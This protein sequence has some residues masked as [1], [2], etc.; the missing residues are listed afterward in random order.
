MSERSS[1]SFASE[2]SMLFSLICSKSL[3]KTMIAK[4]NT[5][6]FL[7]AA[8]CASWSCAALAEPISYTFTAE[9]PIMGALGGA[10]IGGMNGI[11]PT[12][13][14]TFTFVGDTSNVVP[15]ILGPVHGW[16]NLIGTASTTVTDYAT[17]AVIAQGAFLPSDRIFVSVDNVN[18]GVGFG[19]AGASPSDAGFPGNPVYPFGLVS[20]DDPAVFTYDLQSHIAF[21]SLESISCLGFPGACQAPIALATTAGDL[22]FGAAGDQFATV[23]IG[24][25]TANI[26]SAPIPEPGTWGLMAVG[27]AALGFKRRKPLRAVTRTA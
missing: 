23:D 2:Q 3:G 5:L 20:Q 26:M 12:D 27:L 18:G 21:N 13:V 8:V 19:S 17:Q 24:L 16:E 14:I 10:P 15:F 1:A 7:V 4:R 25:F 11:V 6:G 22:V 9:G